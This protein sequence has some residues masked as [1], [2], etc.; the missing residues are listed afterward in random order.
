[1]DRSFGILESVVGTYGQLIVEY[2]GKLQTAMC[3]K[4]ER[5]HVDRMI[6]KIKDIPF[7]YISQTTDRS[8]VLVE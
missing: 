8:F 4:I 3:Y 1:M 2:K 5:H 7:K 6:K